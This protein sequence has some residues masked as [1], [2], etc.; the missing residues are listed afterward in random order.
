MPKHAGPL[1]GAQYRM[2]TLS[3][4]RVQSSVFD[5]IHHELADGWHILGMDEH[6]GPIPPA[7]CAGR[8]AEM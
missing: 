7:G 2:A 3:K 8:P 1:R 4:Q 6:A 5:G